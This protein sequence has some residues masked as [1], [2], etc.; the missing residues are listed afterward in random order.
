[1]PA[2]FT[3]YALAFSGLSDAYLWAGYNEGFITA[4][5][6]R[7][8]AR[9]AA[10]KAVA[11]D[12]RSAEAHTS[13]A[14]FKLFYEFDWP[15]CE[16]EF[17]RAM[18]LNPNCSFAHD[19]FAMALAFQGRFEEAAAEGGRAIELDPLSPQVLVDATIPLIFQR[20]AAA[21]KTLT[22]RAVELDPA[23]F[24]PVMIDGWKMIALRAAPSR[25]ASENAR[26]SAAS[27]ARSSRCRSRSRPWKGS[28]TR[29]GK[30]SSRRRIRSTPGGRRSSGELR[31]G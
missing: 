16:R 24:F 23:L 7:P 13:L 11:L 29:S 26:S 4:T 8:K 31:P 12:D 30:A 14:V 19:Q 17:R 6:A 22:R 10:E 18:A 5:A 15:G 2:A 9:A 20:N 1:M 27:S 28:G 3:D 25:A 21:V